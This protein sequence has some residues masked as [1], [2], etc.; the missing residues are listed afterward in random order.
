MV[1]NFCFCSIGCVLIPQY[2]NAA[3]LSIM[4]IHAGPVASLW[5]TLEREALHGLY[6][7]YNRR[8]ARVRYAVED[9]PTRP[10][11]SSSVRTYEY[12]LRDG[13]RI[14]PLSRSRQSTAGSSLIKIEW[15]GNYR[16]GEVIHIIQHLQGNLQLE[17]D[18]C[19]FAKVRWMKCFISYPST[20]DE[21]PW[22][23][24]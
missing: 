8:G 19:L 2:R 16:A 20:A 10:I 15:H 17:A 24:L 4:P 23:L 1:S 12:A 11:L 3:L 6:L 9:D 5:A 13:R 7:Y 18:D 21:D 14:I 22:E